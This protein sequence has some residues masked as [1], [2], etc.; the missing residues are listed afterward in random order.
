MNTYVSLMHYTAQ[1]AANI[2]ESPAR[3]DAAKKLFAANGGKL[4]EWYLLFGQYDA[5]VIA[6]APD[7]ETAAR[8]I[9]MIASQGNIS[10]ETYRAFP[11][12]DYRKI[13]SS[14]P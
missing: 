5:M 8:V 4:K 11:E 9:M 6:E 3:L 7:D 1:G 13:I 12:D 14:L 10:T 2:K